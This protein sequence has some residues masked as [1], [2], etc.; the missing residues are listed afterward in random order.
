MSQYAA[1]GR[2]I[3]RRTA[4]S[5]RAQNVMSEVQKI[6]E[7]V[8]GSASSS[9]ANHGAS[10]LSSAASAIPIPQ[11][12]NAQQAG[13]DALRSEVAGPCECFE[14]LSC[15][16]GSP[17]SQH[18]LN[19]RGAGRQPLPDGPIYSHLQREVAAVRRDDSSSFTS[20]SSLDGMD[21]QPSG[22]ASEDVRVGS[23]Q[24]FSARLG[25]SPMPMDGHHE[26]HP[27][28]F[29]DAQPG[30]PVHR[31]LSAV[32]VSIPKTL[33]TPS[34]LMVSALLSVPRCSSSLTPRILALSLTTA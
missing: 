26:V 5:P 8:D 9:T 14:Q 25:T 31:A 16:S 29:D 6:V 18:L 11:Q 10:P 21:S 2:G 30:R 1:H 28:Q 23:P 3:L 7:S 4:S 17:G 13:A 20:S 32:L 27:G 19:P 33:S 24:V 22:V 34:G 12:H 15:M